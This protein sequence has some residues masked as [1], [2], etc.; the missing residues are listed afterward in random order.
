MEAGML[1]IARMVPQKVPEPERP[2]RRS[3]EAFVRL[4][5]LFWLLGLFVLASTPAYARNCTAP[6]K[7][8]ADKQ[9]RLSTRDKNASLAKHFPWGVPIA[10]STTDREVILVQRDYALNYDGDLRDPLWVGYKLDSNRL[11]KV[12]RID[13]FRSDVRLKPES[14]SAPSDY[15]EPVYD[16][17]HIAPNGDMSSSINSVLNSFIMS[18]MSPQYCQFNRGVW[19]ILEALVR[20]WAEEKDVLYVMSGSIFD[21]D[22]NQ[23]RDADEDARRM[24]SNNG[25]ER[26]GIASAFYKVVVWEEDEHLNSISFI[27]PHDQTDLDGDEALEYLNTHVSKIGNIEKVSS[28]DILPNAASE[29]SEATKLWSHEGFVSHSLVN[30]VCRRT[31][32]ME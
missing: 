30:D 23:S 6:E 26:V 22:G 10:Q 18:N 17:G 9:L 28:L 15:S 29:P 8:A 14:A 13:C 4:V 2:K 11:G 7:V 27:L 21:Q 19:Q 25:K 32:G 1:V 5:A 24:K 31:E 20:H 12:E 3:P 16:Q